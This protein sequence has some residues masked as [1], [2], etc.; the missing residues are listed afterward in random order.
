MKKLIPILPVLFV[1][2]LERGACAVE[3]WLRILQIG[4]QSEY[5]HERH[6]ALKQ[7]DV[8]SGKNLRILW[9][10]LETQGKKDPLT[11]DWYVRE[12]AYEALSGVETEDAREEILRLLKGNKNHLSKE[13]VVYS[14]IWKIRKDAVKELSQNPD[15]GPNEDRRIEQAKYLLRRTR[16]LEYIK[17]MLPILKKIDSGGERFEWIKIAFQD[18]HSRVRRAALQGFL[19]YPRVD[20]I[21]LLLDNMVK[22]KALEKKSKLNKVRYFREW[23]LN[24][25]ALEQ[26]TGQTDFRDVVEDWQRWWEVA[27][28]KF[29]F[30]KRIKEELGDEDGKDKKTGFRTTVVRRGGVEVK[31]GM[32]IAGRE[33]GYPLLVLPWRDYEPDYFRPYFH[34]LEEFL[35]V[36]YLYTPRIEDFKGLARGAGH[37]II[38]YPTEQLAEALGEYM[39]GIGLKRFAVMGHGQ[40]ASTLAMYIAADPS[41][42]VSHLIL[43]NPRTAGDRYGDALRNVQREGRRRNNREVVKGVDNLF[44]DK[45]GKPSYEPADSF[46]DAGLS[47]AL[48]NLRFADPTAPEVGSM[49][50]LFAMPGGVRVM[51]DDKWSM[52]KVFKSGPPRNLP[53]MVCMGEKDPWTPLGDMMAVAKFFRAQVAKFQGSSEMPFLF[54]PYEFTQEIELFFKKYPPIKMGSKKSGTGKEKNSSRTRARK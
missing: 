21:P 28:S 3:E 24:R 19:V 9:K 44:V 31:V 7:V 37:N 29:S 49:R 20:T 1:L 54:R 13:A 41:Q 48:H 17:L 11:F 45:Q 4:I 42:Q 43:I 53:V 46:E 14:V 35:K 15:L 32:K 6:D 22:L 5:S 26:L 33:D 39:K 23:V 18:P 2:A 50:Y 34:G 40:D 10:V 30:E 52:R 38:I 27:K 8:S 51:A 36:Y 16:G 25:F 47:R 12:G